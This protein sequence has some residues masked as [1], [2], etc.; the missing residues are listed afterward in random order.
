ME[1]IY[2]PY[3]RSEEEELLAPWELLSLQ[4]SHMPLPPA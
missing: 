3:R 2:L 4:V 1:P